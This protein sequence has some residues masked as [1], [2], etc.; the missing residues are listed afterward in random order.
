MSALLLQLVAPARLHVQAPFQPAV[1]PATGNSDDVWQPHVS[2]APDLQLN[3]L[4]DDR[5]AGADVVA[6]SPAEHF[7]LQATTWSEPLVVNSGAGIAWATPTVLAAGCATN[8]PQSAS[9]SAPQPGLCPCP[10]HLQQQVCQL[11]LPLHGPC[12]ACQ[13]VQLLLQ[14]N[15]HASLALLQQ[16][17]RVCV[18]STHHQ[19]TQTDSHMVYLMQFLPAWVLVRAQK[20]SAHVCSQPAGHPLSAVVHAPIK[21]CQGAVTLLLPLQSCQLAASWQQL[22]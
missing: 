7:D 17:V 13:L 6:T 12:W 22:L 16:A 1:A 18:H 14:Y 9:Q 21:P 11:L 20:H 4:P 3:T 10:S 2:D 19:A 5:Q 8:E 15:V